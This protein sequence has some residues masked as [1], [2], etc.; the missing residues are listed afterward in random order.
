MVSNNPCIIAIVGPTCTGKSALA[1][2]LARIFRGEIINADS[3]QVYKYFDIGT[4]KP[5]SLIRKEIP[6]HLIDVVEPFEIFNAARYKEMAEDAIDYICSHKRLPIIVGGTGLYVRAAL[7]GLFEVP[8]DGSLRQALKNDFELDP[9]KSYETLKKVDPAY[10]MKISFRDGIRVI[11]ALE[12]FYLT[13]KSMSEWA[14]I[15]GFKETHYRVY[16]IGLDKPRS[17]LYEKIN[18]RVD[19][20]LEGGWLEEVKN[21][22]AR[23]PEDLKPFS[24]IGYR[25]ILLYFKGAIGYEGMVKDIKKFTRNYAKRQIT[26]FIREKNT[27]WYEYPEDRDKIVSDVAGFLNTWN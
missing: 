1:I 17:I 15:H 20:M 25:E 23:Y 26:W 3:M 6:H 5:D 18:Q 13:G 16:T 14:N 10:A 22:I 2:E 24:S 4:A 11:R 19:Q 8:R 27:V 21:L 7:Y 12:V 9:L